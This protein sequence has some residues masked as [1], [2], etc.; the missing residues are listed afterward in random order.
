MSDKWNLGKKY[1]L[2]IHVTVDIKTKKEILELEVTDEKVH[3]GVKMMKILVE[4]FLLKINPYEKKI[5][6]VLI[7]G[8]YDSNEDFGFLNEKMIKPVI[9]VKRNS[10]I[11]FRNCN[12]RNKETKQQTK[13]VLK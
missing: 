2:K 3:D 12:V 7:D 13:N 6:S 8:A 1:Y 4:D 11:S 5:K 9:E 10:V